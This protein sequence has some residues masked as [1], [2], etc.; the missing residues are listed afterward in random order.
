MAVIPG[1]RAAYSLGKTHSRYRQAIRG[2]GTSGISPQA[3]AVS[4]KYLGTY[5]LGGVLTVITADYDES[6]AMVTWHNAD[7]IGSC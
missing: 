6:G 7:E 3:S 2:S 1:F 5:C 4:G